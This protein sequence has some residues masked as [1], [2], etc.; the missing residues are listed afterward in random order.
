VVVIFNIF[1]LEEEKE[2][3]LSSLVGR[4]ETTAKSPYF[5][6][7]LGRREKGEGGGPTFLTY[8]GWRKS[9]LWE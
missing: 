3:T 4:G 7:R 2:A 8:S 9:T 5:D 6:Q 1:R